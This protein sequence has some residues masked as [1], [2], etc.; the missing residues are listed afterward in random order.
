MTIMMRAFFPP[1]DFD[2]NVVR[3]AKDP[4]WKMCL[5]ILTCATLTLLLGFFSAPLVQFFKVIAMGL[6]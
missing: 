4:G 1:N 5:P 2:K 6:Y 3:N